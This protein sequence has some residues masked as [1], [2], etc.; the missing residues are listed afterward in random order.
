MRSKT[1]F[2]GTFL[3]RPDGSDVVRINETV[4]VLV[5]MIAEGCRFSDMTGVFTQVYPDI[6]PAGLD[7]DIGDT[8]NWLRDKAVIVPAVLAARSA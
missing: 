7:R 4:S 2:G 5:E 3:Y 8:L 6:D 1:A